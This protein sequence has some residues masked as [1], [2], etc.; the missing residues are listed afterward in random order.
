MLNLTDRII[1][2]EMGEMSED[3]AIQLFADLVR[4]GLAWQLQGSY[5]RVCARM[6]ELGYISDKGEV[7]RYLSD[8]DDFSHNV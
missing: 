8:A 1:D 2:F 6:I 4:T 5:G 3:E 7:I